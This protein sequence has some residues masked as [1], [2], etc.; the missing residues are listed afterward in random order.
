MGWTQEQKDQLDAAI[1]SGE[2]EIEYQGNRTKYRSI[3][4]LIKARSLMDSEDAAKSDKAPVA[5]QA[6]FQSRSGW[7][8]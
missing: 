6:V 5:M 3:S 1:V 4:E 7:R 2:L 8:R